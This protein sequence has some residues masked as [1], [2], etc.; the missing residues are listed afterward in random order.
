MA[1]LCPKL[2]LEGTRLTYKTDIAFALN[3]HPR[4]AGPRKYRYP[5]PLISAEWCAFTN[6][7]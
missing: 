6:F 4:I 7:P 1:M 3:E 5:S 2:I